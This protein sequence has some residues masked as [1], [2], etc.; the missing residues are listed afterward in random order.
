VIVAALAVAA[1]QAGRRRAWKAP[2]IASLGAVITWLAMWARTGDALTWLHAEHIGWKEHFDLGVGTAR[3]V[4]TL[5]GTLEVSLRPA[6]LIDLTVAAGMLLAVIGL[7][8]L[9]RWRPPAPVLIYGTG[10]VALA[11]ASSVVGPRP[12]MVLG[13]FPLIMAV[14]VITRGAAYRRILTVSAV[15]LVAMT[16]VTFTTTA[17]AP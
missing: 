1:F 13:A 15:L 9:W 17:V 4:M 14:A 8:A 16:W 6:G 2:V 11:A 3:H 7:V 5:L 12:R 10:A